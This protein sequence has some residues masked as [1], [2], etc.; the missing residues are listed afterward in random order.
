[1]RKVRTE[2][3]R[4]AEFLAAEVV[5]TGLFRRVDL[6]LKRTQLTA[7]RDHGIKWYIPRVWR[8]FL[9]FLT[10]KGNADQLGS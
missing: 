6:V 2:F 9:D 5:E 7:F 10:M 1:M 8:N 3:C 4:F